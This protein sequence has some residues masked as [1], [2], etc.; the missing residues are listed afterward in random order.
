[1]SPKRRT[2]KTAAARPTEV[3]PA[4]RWIQFLKQQDARG[5]ALPATLLFSLLVR[6][7][8]AL[9][10]YSGF[11][12]PPMHGDYEAQRHWMEITAHLPAS[13]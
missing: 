4:Y 10:S 5:V 7:C 8:V 9:H 1:M 6:W 3:V 13:E 12:D 2:A 11:Q